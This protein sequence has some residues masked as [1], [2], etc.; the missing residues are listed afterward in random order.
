MPVMLADADIARL[1][2]ERKVLQTD[3]WKQAVPKPKR[4]HK[5][6]EVSL[7]GD[8]GSEFRLIM[9]ESMFTP[10]DFS[11]IL[12]YLPPK[13]NELFRLYRCNGKS[14]E[15]TNK[16][17]RETFYGFH[18]HMAT[19]RYQA[20]GLDEDAYAK[21]AAHYSDFHGALGHLLDQCGFVRPSEGLFGR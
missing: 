10:L 21:P 19:E 13:T 7:K 8:G 18:V 14:H 16:I 15:H 17:E 11:V 4:G 1:L 12:A 9:R 5:E 2:R 6:S 3:V 20:L